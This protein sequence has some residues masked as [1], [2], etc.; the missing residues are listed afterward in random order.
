LLYSNTT[1][2]LSLSFQTIFKD[3]NN[4]SGLR[5]KIDALI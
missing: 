2:Q 4:N 1:E 3:E 5:F